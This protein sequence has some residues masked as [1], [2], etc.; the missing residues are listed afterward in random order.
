VLRPDYPILTPRLRLRPLADDDVAELLAYRGEPEVCR[1][2]PFEPMDE[3]TVRTR[4]DG[5]LGR[6]A[7][8]EEGQ[9]LTLGVELAATGRL[10]GDVMLFY[11]SAQHS[12]GEIG[13]VFHPDF[14][15]NGYATEACAAVLNLAFDTFSGLG[16][17]RV[18]A[19]MDARNNASERMARRLGMRREAHFLSNEWF[20]GAWADLVVYALLDDEWRAHALAEVRV[21]PETA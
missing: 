8:T 2:L 21:A 11:Q 7:I 6:R 13:Y 19:R 1:Y 3:R 14:T 4:L 9:G 16:L 20:K 18:V 17:H 12:G 5:D 15:G 10:V